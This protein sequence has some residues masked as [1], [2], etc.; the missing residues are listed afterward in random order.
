MAKAQLS[1]AT[2]SE[3]HELEENLSAQYDSVFNSIASKNYRL[4]VLVMGGSQAGKSSLVKIVF[5]NE[6]IPTGSDGRPVTQD[7]G[8][9]NDPKDNFQLIDTPGLEKDVNK[10]IVARIKNQLEERH[11]QPSII[12]IV[13]NTQTSIEDVELELIHVAPN[14]PVIFILNKC[15]FL[16][17]R[18]TYLRENPHCLENFD[19]LDVS[20]LPEW[21]TKNQVMKKRQRL[22][23]WRED[24]KDRVKRIVITSL[25]SGD[26][27]DDTDD[28]DKSIGLEALLEATFG[29]LDDVGRIRLAEIRKN[30]QDGKI[31]GSVAIITASAATATGAAWIPVPIVDTIAISSIQTVM[32]I[33]LYKYWGVAGVDAKTFSIVFLKSLTPV[34]ISLAAGYSASNLCKIFLGIG[35]IVGG[36]LDAFFALSGTLI[37]GGA[38]TLYLSNFIYDVRQFANKE[39]LEKSIEEFMKT[40]RFTNMVDDIK[41]LAKTPN[42]I[43]NQG[44][45]NILERR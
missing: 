40:D 35:S 2:Y 24:H 42:G 32:V 36:A 20:Q 39:Q 5:N 23:N 37:I 34:I 4:S 22:L 31:S 28:P 38:V 7:I 12:W 43:T 9:Y 16:Q 8:V 29:C 18:K 30:S 26:C 1:P 14:T 17:K 25:P 33:S 10:D 41:K 6:N 11:L 45:V 21:M 3:E 15:D 44:I 13:L 19:Q 27:D